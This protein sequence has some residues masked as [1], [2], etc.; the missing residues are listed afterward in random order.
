MASVYEMDGTEDVLD[1]F[2]IS[3]IQTL[4]TDSI[5]SDDSLPGEH[6]DLLK[7]M[8]IR[9]NSISDV[10]AQIVNDEVKFECGRR[11]DIICSMFIDAICAKYNMT[12]DEGWFEERPNKEIH[13]FT[14]M[15]YTFF[16]QDIATILEEIFIKYI[17]Q[18]SGELG[19]KYGQDLKLRKDATYNS[20]KDKLESDF[21]IIVSNIYEICFNI[22][23]TI[24]ESEFFELVDNDYLPKVT[25]IK[26]YNEGHF[27]GEFVDAIY[28]S[29]KKDR[30]MLSRI[31]FNVIAAIKANH[32][33][34]VKDGE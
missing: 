9:Y 22:L 1:Y 5:S 15:L 33:I 31:C 12:I 28:T 8:W 24:S 25:L 6:P 14:V 4:I 34:K 27:G 17:E 10:N 21:A 13:A 30:T 32:K 18:H 29:C 20:V 3:E 7:P 19:E 11:F 23:D 26:Y 2:D 16:I